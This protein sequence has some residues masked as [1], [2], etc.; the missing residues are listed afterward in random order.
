MNLTHPFNVLKFCPRCGSETFKKADYHSFKCGVCGFHYFIN[1]AAAV[2]ALIVNDEGKLMLVK[3][4][5]EPDYGKLDLPGGFVDAGESMEQ[6]LKRE[7]LEELGLEI[8]SFKY[9]ISAPNEY[10]FSDFTVFTLDFAFKVVPQSLNNLH[11]MDDIL[12]YKFYAEEE[13]NYDDIPASSIKY[14]VKQYFQDE[15]NKT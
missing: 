15:R 5:V 9:I 2:A 7:L 10:I 3:R 11:P 6:A 1:A 8:A 4:G 12:N 14:F 13:I